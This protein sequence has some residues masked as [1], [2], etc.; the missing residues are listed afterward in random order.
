[1]SM[2]LTIVYKLS[3]S[4][5]LLVLISVGVIG[6]LFYNK[7]TDLLVQHAL[8]NIAAEISETGSQLQTHIDHQRRDT[9]F[10]AR[11]PPIQGML[12]A[13][14][15]NNYD[16]KGKSTYR[17]WEQRVQKIFI[18]ILKSKPSYLQI[19]FLD[20]NGKELVDVHHEAKT[21]EYHIHSKESL[22]NKSNSAYVKGTLKLAVGAVYLSEI[23]LNR[24]HGEVSKPHTEVLRSATPVYDEQT[25][26]LAGLVVVNVE[27][28]SELRKIQKNIQDKSSEIFITNERGG[29]LLHPDVT[30]AYGFDLGKR[31]RIQEEF[32]QL[33]NLFL[34]GNKD[35][36]VTLYPKDTKGAHVVS[37]VKIPFDSVRP[38]RFIAV[39][40]SELYSSIVAKQSGVQSDVLNLAVIMA[41]VVMLLAIFFSY[42]LAIPIK[43]IARVMDDYIHNRE[44]TVTMPL[45]DKS[46]VGDLARRYHSLIAEVEDAK[47]HLKGLNSNLEVLVEE[48]TVDLNASRIEAERANAAKSEFLSRM[49]HELR[50]PMNAI[51][52]FG[53]IL[54]MESENFN[55]TQQSNIREIL[56]AGY[57]LLDLI[58]EVLDLS[59][60]ESGKFEISMEDVCL[61]DVVE[62]SL[63]LI[64]PLVKKRHIEIVDKLSSTGYIVRADYTRVKQVL[65]N[66]LS[67][68]V[69]YNTESG[70]ITLEAVYSESQPDRIRISVADTGNGLTE[71]EVSKLFTA[72]ERLNEDDKTEGTG[73]GLVITKHLIE[74]MNGSIEV[75]CT[76][77]EGCIFW[78]E[79]LLAKEKSL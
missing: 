18:A 69:K 3:L 71:K 23:N 17:Q 16:E 50:T 28:G 19:R 27:I 61:D 57:H 53:Q 31:F 73:I 37:F 13:L 48:R 14:K 11:T 38:E 30:K 35:T 77:G 36:R 49:S 72:F 5:V 68:A 70:R 65:V 76:P 78:I 47:A 9:L 74:Q 66:L 34:P 32:P 20:H 64:S 1:M 39:G 15:N 6:G 29:Y 45:D 2:K 62:K 24:E 42:R 8:E 40:I 56:Q 22:Q 79:L 10:I 41:V 52:G 67:N 60:I 63:S 44:S 4:A 7:T 43:N 21:D 75:E 59:R 58:N 25:G 33:A 46:E 12:R 54:D 26:S 55:E 51:L